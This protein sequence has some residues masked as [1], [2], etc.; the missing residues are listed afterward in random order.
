MT[1]NIK[2]DVDFRYTEEDFALTEDY[3]NGYVE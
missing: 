1:N 2:E 3:K